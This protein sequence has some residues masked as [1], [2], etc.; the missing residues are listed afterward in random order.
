MTIDDVLQ[1][2]AYKMTQ[3]VRGLGNHS[4]KHTTDN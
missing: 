4:L 2:Y 1:H 3:R